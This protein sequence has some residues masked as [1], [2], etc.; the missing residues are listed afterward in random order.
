MRLSEEMDISSDLSQENEMEYCKN[1]ILEKWVRLFGRPFF[2][3]AD[4]ISA[5]ETSVAG[6]D[7]TAVRVSY[8]GELGWELA[9]D[10]S[11]GKKLWNAV[12]EQATKVGAVP[13][14]RSAL[15]SLRL[16]KGYRAW[17]SDMSRE[18]TPTSAG[19]EFAVYQT[20]YRSQ[21]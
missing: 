18:D 14:G 4:A 7:V 15:T 20:G 3:A 6:V 9:C 5:K 12:M 10:V 11:G 21:S 1:F 16:E 8:V 13:A 2:D 19:L 17:G